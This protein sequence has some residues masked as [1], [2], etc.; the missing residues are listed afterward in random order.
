MCGKYVINQLNCFRFG[1]E[2][3]SVV[4]VIFSSFSLRIRIY[5]SCVRPLSLYF[6]A[7]LR[8]ESDVYFYVCVRNPNAW[9]YKAK[10]PNSMDK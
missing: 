8:N 9:D 7:F 3:V 1:S 10:L 4:V 5:L 2:N 6:C